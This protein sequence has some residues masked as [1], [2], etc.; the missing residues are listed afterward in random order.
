MKIHNIRFGFAT[1][2]SSSHSIIFDPVNYK[3]YSDDYKD[4]GFGWD[5]FTLQSKQAK[6]EYMRA[7]LIQ[8]LNHDNFSEILIDLIL[9]GLNLEE[10][11]P[12]N[13]GIDH[14]S[15]FY[16]PKEF[17]TNFISMEFFN[18]FRRYINKEGIIILGGN[19][20]V[21]IDNDDENY[22]GH[23][24]FDETKL[25]QFNGLGSYNP[26]ER[27]WVC[28]KDGSW[29]TLYNRVSGNRVVLSFDDNPEPFAP[30]NPMLIDFKMTDW[31]DKNCSFCYQGSTTRGEHMNKEDEYAFVDNIAKAE[32]FEV[33]IGGG[34]PTKY[35]GFT[36]FVKI[37]AD[38]GVVVNFTT[39][40]I[41]WLENEK[42]ANDIIS[43]IG[44]FAFS[45]NDKT[46][47]LDRILTIMKYRGYDI[48]KFNVQV[49]P[50]TMSEFY[51]S[52]SIRIQRNRKRCSI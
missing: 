34:E 19:D 42:T 23:P 16:I 2:S 8:N 32:V 17:G 40:S 22:N 13:Y 24:L 50:A 48:Q 15:L 21:R 36:H 33:A 30:K 3:K 49:V 39:R 38:R 7:M 18:D 46:N 5:F 11:V 9:K 1:N 4:D 31:C 12:G 35:P 25:A 28:R 45:L 52:Y 43:N 41:E 47:D 44:A 51:S 14:Q 37:L 20:N 10:R 6:D 27:Y 26:D 29:W